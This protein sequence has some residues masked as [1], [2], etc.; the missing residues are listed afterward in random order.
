MEKEGRRSRA[1]TASLLCKEGNEEAGGCRHAPLPKDGA[2]P[3]S[4]VL[5]KV[6]TR[7]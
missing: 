3:L 5:T 7:R 6:G 2:E 1:G 4:V